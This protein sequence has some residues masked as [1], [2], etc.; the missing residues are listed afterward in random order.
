M[1]KKPSFNQ[2]KKPNDEIGKVKM[3]DSINLDD[4]K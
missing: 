3:A 2:N 1:I 4:R